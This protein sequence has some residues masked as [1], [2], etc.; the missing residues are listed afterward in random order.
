MPPQGFTNE[1]AHADIPARPK[2]RA[3]VALVA[4]GTASV[5][6]GGLLNKVIH[7]MQ[8]SR[9]IT[10]VAGLSDGT[11]TPG[12][13]AATMQ[14]PLPEVYAVLEILY[15]SGALEDQEQAVDVPGRDRHAAAFASQYLSPAMLHSHSSQVIND[16]AA[17]QALVL[18]RSELSRAVSADLT[19]AGIK[20][21]SDLP[22]GPRPVVVYLDD[23]ADAAAR[24][25]A[26]SFLMAGLPVL[27][28]AA[29][30]DSIEVGPLFIGGLTA[31]LSCFDTSYPDIAKPLLDRRP[32]RPWQ[33]SLASGMIVNEAVALAGCLIAPMSYRRLLRLAFP[34]FRWESPLLV[35]EPGC[36]SCGAPTA[37]TRHGPAENTRQYE[38]LAEGRPAEPPFLAMKTTP[39]SASVAAALQTARR[40]YPT[41]PRVVLPTVS[42]GAGDLDR[43]MLGEILVRISG[44]MPPDAAS[45]DHHFRW[46]PSGGNLGSAE[47]HVMTREADDLGL[48][49]NIAKYD[50]LGHALICVRSGVTDLAD[51]LPE[52]GLSQD[53]LLAVL[54]LSAAI[55]RV[56][57]KYGSF[58][59]RLVHLD[60]GCALTQ[61]LAVA[62]ARGYQVALADGWVNSTLI[63]ALDLRPPAE[64]V[65]V[66]AGLYHGGADAVRD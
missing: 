50:D 47:V 46:A 51:F 66:V 42:T 39:A 31:C 33:T 52:T 56:A 36:R 3:G 44:F 63:E 35:P 32:A 4:D 38:W 15:E 5:L 49:G 27:R 45:R 60:A 22:S 7:G 23:G 14:I 25:A 57:R 2:L 24:S 37:G 53:G 18:G 12:E 41:C 17:A 30:A 19:A 62:A 48:P 65:T 1:S 28:A 20:V 59:Y 34:E 8:A 6:V 16:L 54:V 10:A 64:I 43:G 21:V 58:A 61:L 40:E 13:I 55:G 9:A 26:E 29:T 11:R